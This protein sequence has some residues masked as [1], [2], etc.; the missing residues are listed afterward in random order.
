M[1]C[2]KIYAMTILEPGFWIFKVYEKNLGSSF[3]VA[4]AWIFRQTL[5]ICGFKIVV[6]AQL[7]DNKNN[8]LEVSSEIQTI[9]AI[10][11]LIQKFK[12]FTNGI[13]YPPPQVNKNEIRKFLVFYQ[14]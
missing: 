10:L 1:I 7:S 12:L 6:D 9:L 13:N 3:K 11:L 5:N 8:K 4:T 2:E 14:S